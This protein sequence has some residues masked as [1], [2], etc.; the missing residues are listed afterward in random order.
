[1]SEWHPDDRRALR[2]ILILLGSFFVIVQIN[3][4]A[5]GV[6]ANYLGS[7]RGLSPTD[8]GTVMGAMFFASAVVQLPTGLLFD[9]IGAKRTLVAMGLV[10]VCGIV[11]F[12]VAEE[13]WALVTGRF[14]IGLGHGGVITAVY[15]IAMGWAPPDRV[16]QATASLV[17]I[18]GGIGGVMA[19]APLELLLSEVGLTT[20]F[21]VV[22]ALT[23]AFTIVIQFTVRDGPASGGVKRDPETFAQSLAGLLEVIRMP[24]LRRIYVMGFCFTAPFMTIGGLWAGPYFTD[25]QGL[26]HE[27]ASIALLIMVVAL[28]VGTFLYGPLER[29]ATSRKRLILSA[30]ALEIACLGV[31]AVWPSAPIYVAGPILFVFGCVAPFFV[32]LASHARGFVPPHRAGRAIT[33]INLAGLTGVFVLQ[34]A[35][36]GAIDWVQA[37]GGAAETGHRIVFVLVIAALALSALAYAGQPEKPAGD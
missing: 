18:A 29:F 16:A 31:L 14:M 34:T 21:L 25:V 13:T 10:A 19:T 17:G 5:G 32:V 37:T 2:N 22:A 1:M 12:A 23:L 36:G 35:T 3:R 7:H 24:E 27:Q 9:R 8:I 11:L 15:L 26:S 33:T 30:V 6:L 20:T 4:S 28:H